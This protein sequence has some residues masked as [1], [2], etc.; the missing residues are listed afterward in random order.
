MRGASSGHGAGMPDGDPETA[1]PAREAP[2]VRSTGSPAAEAV[3]LWL[4]IAAAFSWRLLLLTV[5]AIAVVVVVDRLHLVFLPVL[6]ALLLATF[7]EPPTDWLEEA[8]LPRALAAL[9]SLVGGI[10]VL[11]GIA[12]LIGPPMVDATDDLGDE[13]T[14]AID[15]VQEWL[16]EGPLD[17][18][19]EQIAD[20]VDRAAD[21]L[22]ENVGTIT[23]RLISGAVLVVEVIA[24]LLLTIVLLFFFLKDGR[25]IWAWILG[26]FGRRRADVDQLGRRAWATLGGYIRGI[27]AVATIDATFIGLALIVIGVPLVLPLVVITFFGAY[28]PIVGAFVSG[29]LAVLVALASLGVIEALLVLAAIIVVQ[30]VEGNVLQPVIVGRSVELHPVV[31][32][33]GVT[34]GAVL[35]GIVGAFLA[36]PLVA[37]ASSMIAYARERNAADGH[38]PDQLELGAREPP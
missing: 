9:T 7:L 26:L 30:Q 19:Q 27:T 24:G 22:R 15:A 14:D 3:P 36:V 37:V 38:D 35:Y 6:A 5:T 25:G 11:V 13:L 17:L 21:Q 12:A 34:G 29:L 1:A 33:L 20:T 18:S 31:I 2:I 32:L 8:G 16:I 4:R 28:I 10:A 23:D